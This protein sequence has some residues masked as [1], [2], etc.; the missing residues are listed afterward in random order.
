TISNDLS[1][2][3]TNVNQIAKYCNK[4]Q[5]ESPNYESLERNINVVRE[6]LNKVW[7][8]LN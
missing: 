4:H 8:K 5:H 1:K 2:L 3:G 6:R 7:E